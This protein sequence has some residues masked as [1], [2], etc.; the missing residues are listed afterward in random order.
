MPRSKASPRGQRARHWMVTQHDLDAWWR[1]TFHEHHAF[2]YCAYQIESTKRDNWHA[3]IYLQFTVQVSGV[4]IQE[5]CGGSNPHIEVA[6]HPVEAREYCMKERTRVTEPVEIGLWNPKWVGGH[7]TD[8]TIAKY[9]IREN[10]NIRACLD[11]D[12]LDVITSK[13]PKWVFDQLSMVTH[14]IRQKPI[15]HAYYGPTG[16]GKT[17]RVFTEAPGVVKITNRNGFYNYAGQRVVLFDEF[18]KA[19]FPIDEMLQMMDK[20][21][22]DVNV[23]HGWMHWEV[24]NIYIT[25]SEHPKDWYIGKTHNLE[26]TNQQLLRRIDLIEEM[27]ETHV[28]LN[29]V[30][31]NSPIPEESTLSAIIVPSPSVLD[32]EYRS[33][34]EEQRKQLNEMDLDSDTEY[35]IM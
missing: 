4:L 28:V 6:H 11:D 17:T 29:E 16:T 21:P 2:R 34:E 24:S 20:F 33:P 8:L 12:T 31:I 27:I 30:D 18:D 32:R 26:S 1:A 10:G 23:K 25:A 14:G 22:Y 3:Q 15:V 9:K 7:R 35:D 13:Y 19:P 5:L